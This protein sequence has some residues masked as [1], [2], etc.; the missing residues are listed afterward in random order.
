MVDLPAYDLAFNA[1]GDE[2]LAGPTAANAAR[3]AELC[4][5]RLLN[6][7]D[8]IAR[9]RRDLAGALFAGVPGVKTPQTVRVDAAELAGGVRAAAART[10]IAEPFL[11][12][13]IGSHGGKGLFLV[14]GGAPEEPLT[15]AS[16][17]YL[18]QF[19]NFR[20]PDGLHRKYRELFVG[21]AT[22][23]Y[24]AAALAGLDDPLRAL[25]DAEH[26][27]ERLRRGA[28]RFPGRDPA[29][30]IGASGLGRRGAERRRRD[31]TGLRRGRL[32]PAT[33]RPRAV[34]RSQRH[35]AGASRS[36]GELLA[37]KNPAIERILEAFN[38]ILLAG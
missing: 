8:K 37:H 35:H 31:G 6:P 27:P 34:V 10:G 11:V 38:G 13:P 26:H 19:E 33:R 9:T 18:T 29:G 7:P 4:Q 28:V 32:H 24:H 16:A 5:T 1:I 22:L 17:Y 14:G 23:P 2:D 12:R 21:G 30:A 15:P 3:F 36:R 20:S 25:R